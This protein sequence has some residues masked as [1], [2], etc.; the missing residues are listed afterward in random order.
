MESVKRERRLGRWDGTCPAAMGDREGVE[1]SPDL[2][3]VKVERPEERGDTESV[4]RN[5]IE[6]ELEEEEEGGGMGHGGGAA[7]IRMATLHPKKTFTTRREAIHGIQ[8]F[9]LQQGKRAV[10][11]LKRSGGRHVAIVCSSS[12]P[13]SFKVKLTKLTGERRGF[14][15]SALCTDHHGCTGTAKIT[16]RQVEVNTTARSAFRA[17]PRTS[18]PT[19]IAQ[20]ADIAR[21][22][23]PTRMMYRAKDTCIAANESA[24]HAGF[25]FINSLVET[26]GKLNATICSV[27]E[28]AGIF[29]GAFIC[30]PIA[31]SLQPSLQRVVGID[32]SHMKARAYNGTMLVLVGRD[33]NNRNVLLAVALVPS[34]TAAAYDWFLNCCTTNDIELDGTPVF[35]D[36][37]TGILASDWKDLMLIHCTRHLICNGVDN[38]GSAFTPDLQGIIYDAQGCASE[39]A[40]RSSLG[41]LG[42]A[43][44]A[45]ATYYNKIDPHTW[46]L[47]PHL[48]TTPL[49][50]WRTT[51]FVES[52]NSEALPAREMDPFHF[53]MHHMEDMMTTAFAHRS[54]AEKWA[55]QGRVITPYAQG[56]I[57]AQQALAPRYKVYES[58]STRAYV[59]DPDAYASAKR[60][61]DLSSRSCTCGY[62][63]QMG[64]PC[65]HYI[66]ALMAFGRMPELYDACAVCY[67]VSAINTTWTSVAGIELPIAEELQRDNTMMPPPRQKKAGRP[68]K[69]R[70]RNRGEGGPL[71]LTRCSFC[72][73]KGHNK[74]SCPSK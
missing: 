71:G 8:D 34:E 46:A 54:D 43:L 26:F 44:P 29:W 66:R 22:I 62:M 69:R 68:K 15:V 70:I 11:D 61:V 53:L 18:A 16:Q 47:Y 17:N 57:D 38:I 25:E 40:F 30:N 73:A 33:G 2:S 42:V 55:A 10:L 63:K 60:R 58:T 37:G 24:A 7:H 12:T 39:A 19:V 65:R 31:R 51:N 27:R 56:L 14:R 36:R 48:H 50:G 67:Q 28:D 1:C 9:A 20:V 13:C 32:G 5:F 21:V 59:K 52:T 3:L 64:L 74:R 23:V 72:H 4:D 49:Y 45:A 41:C 35:C 6:V